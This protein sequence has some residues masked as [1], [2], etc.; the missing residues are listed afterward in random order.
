MSRRH[1]SL[2]K[3]DATDALLLNHTKHTHTTQRYELC[4]AQI[5]DFDQSGP[6][7]YTDIKRH[8]YAQST[9]FVVVTADGKAM[10]EWPPPDSIN[11]CTAQHGRYLSPL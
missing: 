4:R 9:E 1:A 10:R 2:F 6:E 7:N 5:I 3:L 11:V 8:T